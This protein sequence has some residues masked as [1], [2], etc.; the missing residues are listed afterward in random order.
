[1]HAFAD[2]D[3]ARYRLRVIEYCN[4]FGIDA[5][6]AAFPVKRSTVFLWKK[7]LKDSK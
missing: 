1:M 7:T 6:L 2:S 5:T 4:K 3:T